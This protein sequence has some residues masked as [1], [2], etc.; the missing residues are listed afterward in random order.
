MSNVHPAFDAEKEAWDEERMTY[1]RL[2]PA[3]RKM[4]TEEIR[5]ALIVCSTQHI[6]LYM[7]ARIGQYD[8]RMVDIGADMQL[9]HHEK[10]RK[11]G[12]AKRKG[13]CT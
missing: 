8:A 1:P 12:E 2:M 4:C 5:A 13:A 10:L 6:P 7:N 9:A 11:R 3:G